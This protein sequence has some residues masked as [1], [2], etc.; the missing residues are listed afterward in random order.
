MIK[1]TAKPCQVDYRT[2]RKKVF[3]N[4][5]EQADTDLESVYARP[6]IFPVYQRTDIEFKMTFIRMVLKD[7]EDSK[8]DINALKFLFIRTLQRQ[9][10]LGIANRE[11][12]SLYRR[13]FK[14]IHSMSVFVFNSPNCFDYLS[15][16]E[17]FIN[18]PKP[19]K[20]HFFPQW[21]REIFLLD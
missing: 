20:K 1:K 11:E 8:D 13:W 21:L 19:P 3:D 16:Y 15:D 14:I 5:L 7:I 10:D 9:I 18:D 12:I 2:Y 17:E 4:L 6:E